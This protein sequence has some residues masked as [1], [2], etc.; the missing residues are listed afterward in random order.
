MTESGSV[1]TVTPLSKESNTNRGELLNG[2]E[3]FNNWSNPENFDPPSKQIFHY[4]A[5]HFNRSIVVPKIMIN[6]GYSAEVR[7]SQYPVG[8]NTTE[9]FEESDTFSKA[10]SYRIMELEKLLANKNDHIE[11]LNQENKFLSEKVADF[12]NLKESERIEVNE[13]RTASIIQSILNVASKGFYLGAALFML[14]AF[15]DIVIPRQNSIFGFII[16]SLFGTMFLL[17]K[18]YRRSINNA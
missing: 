1:S 16:L 12:N 6:K 3:K 8:V 7:I 15:L 2:V 9:K 4:E 10:E 11:K 13:N 14:F 17:D 18:Y 5:E